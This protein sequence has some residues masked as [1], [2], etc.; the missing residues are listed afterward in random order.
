MSKRTL[1]VQK[2][3]GFADSVQCP[4]ELDGVKR[5]TPVAFNGVNVS[6]PDG[7]EDKNDIYIVDK[8][9]IADILNPLE[10]DYT[11]V[12]KAGE[13]IILRN[14]NEGYY[15]IDGSFFASKPSAGNT[16]Q[17]NES[18]KFEVGAEN[19]VCQ[20]A[21]VI[22]LGSDFEVIIKPLY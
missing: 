20:V 2:F 11:E 21:K 1:I 13:Y 18:G 22:D 8:I 4:E 9:E 14:I 6:I 15:Q 5:G 10:T 16:L 19:P 3:W 17:I 12:V 7:S